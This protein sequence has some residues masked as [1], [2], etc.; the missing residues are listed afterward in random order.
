VRGVSG[1][2]IAV[3]ADRRSSFRR[4]GSSRR[5]SAACAVR[6]GRSARRCP[7]R[8]G[9]DVY[10]VSRQ[11]GHSRAS[12]T[13]D[14]YAHEFEKAQNGATLRRN[15]RLRSVA[16]SRQDREASDV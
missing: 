12:I 10:S 15:S 13:L 5:D 2:G 1:V 8:A 3:S 7:R 11:L 16:S 4:W 6:S 14:I 9:A